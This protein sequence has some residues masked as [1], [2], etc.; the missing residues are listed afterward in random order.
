MFAKTQLRKKE[1]HY[2]IA[3]D[4]ETEIFIKIKLIMYNYTVFI[5]F[6]GS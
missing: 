1:K 3:S 6:E 5:G 2:V 4:I